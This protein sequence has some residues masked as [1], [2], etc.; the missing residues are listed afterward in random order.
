[1]KLLNFAIASI[2]DANTGNGINRQFVSQ[3][4][5]NKTDYVQHGLDIRAKSILALIGKIKASVTQ[6]IENSK[7]TAQARRSSKEVLQMSEHM[8]KDVGL[9]YNDLNDLRLGLISLNTLNQRRDQ[10]RNEQDAGLGRLSLQQV[11]VGKNDLE[12]SN[13]EAYELAKCA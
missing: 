7:A 11:S 6:Y 13:E 1:M 12:S 8:M 10:N 4:G 5:S 3:F 9:T 2:V